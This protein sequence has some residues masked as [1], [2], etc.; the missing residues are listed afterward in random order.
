MFSVNVSIMYEECIPVS[1]HAARPYGVRRTPLHLAADPKGFTP[2]VP[3]PLHLW[4][5]HGS[6][7]ALQLPDLI[8]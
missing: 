3:T 5:A 8:A 7:G 2:L 4:L 6:F 1:Q